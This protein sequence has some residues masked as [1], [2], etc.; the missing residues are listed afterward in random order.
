MAAAEVSERAYDRA[1]DL[2]DR[3]YLYPDE[4]AAPVLLLSA[5]EGVADEVDWLLVEAE[6]DAVL[7][8]HGD[9]TPIGSVSVASVETLPEALRALESV[10][11]DAG[12][13]LDADVDLRLEI[14][15]GLTQSLDRYSRILEGERL[16]RFDQRLKGTLVGI[17]ATI[18]QRS[19]EL[20]VT[21][22]V[23]D[24]PAARGEL[25]VGDI[26]ERIDGKATVNMPLRE[27]TR[28][29]RGE[30]DSDVVLSVRRGE[31][32]LAVTLTRAEVIL[33]NVE[34]EVLPGN[35]GYMRIDHFSQK[36]VRNMTASM[37]ELRAAGALDKGLVIDLRGNTGGSMKEAARSADQFLTE[38]MLLR[39]AGPDGGRVANLQARMDA[40]DA[41]NEPDIAVAILVDE[42]TAS[43]SE[44]L[45]GALLEL[46]R[47]VL[48]GTR[49]YGK[50]TVQKIYNLDDD[51]RLKLTVAQ[52]LLAGDRS[53]AGDGLV[54]DAVL[55]PVE[56]GSLGARFRGWSEEDTGTSWDRVVPVVDEKE[57]WRGKPRPSDD[58]VV[59]DVAR[60]AVLRS[61]DA[62]RASVLDAL[63]EVL[64]E[65]R[66]SEEGLLVEALAEREIDWTPAESPL[67]GD[68]DVTVVLRT[69]TSPS[70]PDAITVH[71]QVAN[72]G[73]APLHRAVV[74][75][76]CESFSLWEGL[77]VPIGLVA[78]GQEAEGEIGVQ[79]R[80]GID[81]RQDE[82]ALRLRADKAPAVDVGHEVLRSESSKRPRLAVAAHLQ[83][84]GAERTAEI[85]V[86]NISNVSISGLEVF[87][88]F[89]GDV[90]VELIDRAGRVPLMLGN[91]AET[92][93][94][95]MKVGP[96]APDRL[97]LNL[98]IEGERFNR[99]ASWPIEL[100]VDGS[101][102]SIRAPE[103]ST[104]RTVLSAPVGPFTLPLLVTDESKVDHL[105]VYA[106]GDKVAWAGAGTGQVMLDAAI[107]LQPGSNSIVA[108]AED[109]HGLRTREYYAIRGEV[110]ATV[111]AGE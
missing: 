55:R 105:V 25:H 49:S 79:L 88:S 66:T 57:S 75:L 95:A 30:L 27:A 9:G 86:S 81:P 23:P 77:V 92:F 67:E 15:R 52:Y 8:R 110:S 18:S 40:I 45:A 70:R 62:S 32:Q 82:V 4:I 20:R 104:A 107:E 21:H 60:R 63:D 2:I 54:P 1:I 16:Q 73:D 19:D 84:E 47:A 24:G 11:R 94:L 98:N 50:G 71:A 80:P 108:V 83:G 28:R 6:G 61:R 48:V 39:T 68:P 89:P 10:V 3:L 65:V 22:I 96:N 53:I 36:T 56:L 5:A 34:H 41:G 43:G 33:P 90:D 12:H 76:D 35:I 38:G 14:L 102:V 91:D 85:T 7:L 64:Q 31:Q 103:L 44:I 13:P 74:E 97:P 69:S 42:R 17:G 111:D 26:I 58:D 106:N 72:H 101:P 51:A 109:E 59:R 93:T 87:F 99:I 100:P 37:R 29:I 78:P 46:D